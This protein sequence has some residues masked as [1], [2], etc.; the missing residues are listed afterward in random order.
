MILVLWGG[1]SI[2]AISKLNAKASDYRKR[3]KYLTNLGKEKIDTKQVLENNYTKIQSHLFPFFNL[4]FYD[5][6]DTDI[7]MNPVYK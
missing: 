5:V 7:K 6:L 2:F 4:F 1:L 3:E